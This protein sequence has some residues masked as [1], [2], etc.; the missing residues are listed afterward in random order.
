MAENDGS[1]GG[2]LAG[3]VLLVIVIALVGRM[4]NS[5]PTPP[6][7]EP[8]KVPK[9]KPPKVDI[10]KIEIPQFDP[11][12]PQAFRPDSARRGAAPVSQPA[13]S[14]ASDEH[15]LTIE[16]GTDRLAVVRIK[17]LR[18]GGLRFEMS[19]DAG[20]SKSHSIPDGQ[21]FEVVRF[22]THD[23]EYTYSKGEGF[24]IDPPVGKVS[25]ATLTLHRVP[26]GNYDTRPCSKAD[27]E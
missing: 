22:G 1:K 23:R 12:S 17:D 20:Q 15:T 24:D 19:L 27:F 25:H 6:Q 21:F 11:I 4:N 3:V 2:S 10:P 7:H 5:S 9:F 13:G 18:T 8:L 14:Y 26:S 16:N